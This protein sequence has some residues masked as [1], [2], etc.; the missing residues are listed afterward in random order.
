MQTN[1]YLSIHY[2]IAPCHV[3]TIEEKIKVRKRKVLP[4]GELLDKEI[5]ILVP[6][7]YPDMHA[8]QATIAKI[9]FSG[10]LKPGGYIE[11]RKWGK[12]IRRV[13]QGTVSTWEVIT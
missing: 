4:S 9:L 13:V 12:P 1:T 6:K 7:E 2:S 10:R 8:V 11:V 3:A 5:E